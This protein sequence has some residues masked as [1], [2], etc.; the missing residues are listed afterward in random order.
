VN[1]KRKTLPSLDSDSA[2]L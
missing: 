1:D 2:K